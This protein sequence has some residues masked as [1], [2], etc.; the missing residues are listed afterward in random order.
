MI[1][2][3]DS[4]LMDSLGTKLGVGG[5]TAKLKLPLLAVEGSLCAGCTAFMTAVTADT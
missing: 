5:L 4:D 1:A 3:T 2:T